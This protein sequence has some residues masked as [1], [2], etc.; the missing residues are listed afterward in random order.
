MI[1]LARFIQ[2]VLI[3]VMEN[4]PTT[5]PLPLMGSRTGVSSRGELVE[6]ESGRARRRRQFEDPLEVMEVQWNFTKDEF[7]D[8]KIFFDANLENGSLSF[9]IEA[10]GIV[11]FLNGT[12]SFSRSDN[13][14]TVAASLLIITAIRL[15]FIALSG[16][17][18]DFVEMGA[19][20]GGVLLCGRSISFLF[21]IN[22][23]GQFSDSVR[24][25]AS[26]DEILQAR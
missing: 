6:M 23:S 15:E 1:L 16:Q 8:F 5:L 13:L 25:A 3:L 10:Y 11:A 18:S 22:L 20:D 21:P 4:W 24:M 2:C 26:T 17:H 19:E 12:Y 14:F 9:I 7:D